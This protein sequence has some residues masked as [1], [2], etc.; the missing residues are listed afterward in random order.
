[1][2]PHDG[3]VLGKPLIASSINTGGDNSQHNKDDCVLSHELR[4][5]H[6]AVAWLSYDCMEGL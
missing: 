5:L 6:R 3:I 2:L 1:M 4:V